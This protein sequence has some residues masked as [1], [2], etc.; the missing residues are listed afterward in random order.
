[1]CTFSWW[2]GKMG[3]MWRQLSSLQLFSPNWK[4]WL[5]LLIPGWEE[6]GGQQ[7]CHS[8][9]KSQRCSA[10][11]HQ[12]IRFHHVQN[13][14]H[15]IYF[16]YDGLFKA[17]TN[18]TSLCQY[19]VFKDL[20]ELELPKTCKTEFPDVDDLLNFKL[21]IYPDE[22]RKI[23][24]LYQIYLVRLIFSFLGILQGRCLYLCIQ[25]RIRISSWA[26]QGEL[27]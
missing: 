13:S 16:Q 8:K 11:D 26:A 7:R 10:Q 19:F 2:R 6:G 1:M 9:E 18:S 5:I 3:K 25:N 23:G 12:G 27:N 14:C 4:S 17:M 20:N 24:C 21:I 15:S 22:V